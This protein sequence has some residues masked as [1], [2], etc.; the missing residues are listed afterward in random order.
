M[1]DS[2]I[3]D[4]LIV[5]SEAD[6]IKKVSAKIIDALKIYKLDEE[7]VFDIKLSTEEALRNAMQHGN[8]NNEKLPIEVSFAVDNSV[9]EITIEDRGEGFD[10]KNT[11][12]PTT[13]KNILRTCGRGVFLI[14]KLMDEVQY[15]EKG[16]RIRMVKRLRKK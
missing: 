14:H 5:P 6:E 11:P 2:G 12:D 16:N 4:F 10:Y 15:N 3:K 8:K 7:T 9:L 1:A 13:D